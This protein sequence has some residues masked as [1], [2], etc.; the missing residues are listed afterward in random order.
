MFRMGVSLVVLAAALTGS[1]LAQPQSQNSP[2]LSWRLERQIEEHII[3]ADGTEQATY[4]IASKILKEPAIEPLKQA[5][6]RYSRSAQTLEILE[7]Y[8]RKADGRRLDA[9][10]TN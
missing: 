5:N 3:A 8:T 2:D 1:C 4:T 7:A 10:K 6:V 9:P